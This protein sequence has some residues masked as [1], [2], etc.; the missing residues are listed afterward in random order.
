MVS[1]AAQAAMKGAGILMAKFAMNQMTGVV[2]AMLSLFDENENVD[3]Q[4]TRALT[5]FLI[6]RGV[7]GLYLTG[8]TGEG[9]MMDHDE[10]KLVVETV[11]DQAAGRIPTIVH[12]G[13]IG[14][15]KSILLA[16]HA[17]AAGADA[18]SSVPPFYWKFSNDDIFNYYKDLSEATSLPMVVYSVPL[19]GNLGADLIMRIA[20]LPNVKGLKFTGKDHDQLNYLKANLGEDFI[21]YSGCDEMALSGLSV[22]ADGIIGSFYNVMPELFIEIFK[23]VKASDMK[24]GLR[25]QRIAT[26]I[27]LECI[28]YD[29]LALMRN[30]IGWQGV[31]AG[32]SRRPFTNYA[33]GELG[34][35]KKKLLAIQ[36]KYGVKEQEVCFFA[37][38][39]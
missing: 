38:M 31:D 25:L 13:D 20:E 21:I 14:T 9:F 10:R 29:Y 12:I 5:E 33:D 35:L 18:I 4:R 8:S 2:P 15:K 23:A 39:K 26:E 24:K 7:N 34:D 28:K 30:M 17:E 22:G 37:G 32:Y 11:I 1:A 6:D 19:A 3:V 16:K 27:I 36:E